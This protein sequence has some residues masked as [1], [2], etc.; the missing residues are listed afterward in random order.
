VFDKPR[1]P[2]ADVCIRFWNALELD[3]YKCPIN[4]ICKLKHEDIRQRILDLDTAARN[5]LEK[6]DER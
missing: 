5:W 2:Y 4:D 3:C 6:N 1:R